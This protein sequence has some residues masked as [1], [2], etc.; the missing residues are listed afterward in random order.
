M[1]VPLHDIVVIGASAGGVETLIELCHLLPADLPAAVFVVLHMPSSAPGLLP[2][3]LSRKGALPAVFA[4]NDQ[5]IDHKIIY[6]APPD[7]HML[8]TENRV[9]LSSGPR[10]NMLRPAADTLF[11]S[12]AQA[13]G[14]RVV[15]IVL[16]GTRNDGT[17]GML[18]IQQQGGV[19]IVQDPEEALFPGMPESV[20]QHMQPAYVLKISDIAGTL[21][22]LARE[23]MAKLKEK[24]MTNQAPEEK[25]ELEQDKLAFEN[26]AKDRTPRTLL[27]CPECS[28]V[29]WEV[30][31]G[32]LT[33]YVC[34]IGHA[35][36]E[37]ALMSGQSE[38][39]ER[40]L[41][42]AVRALDERA[43]LAS[44]AERSGH[45]L[46]ARHFIHQASEAEKNAEVIRGII[47]NGS[48]SLSKVDH[49]AND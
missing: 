40:A 1:A 3:I 14:Q 23:P 12:A 7:R 35:Y 47:M 11:R 30:H 13:F 6:V 42:V 43:T 19:T 48:N 21:N 18:A 46:T 49:S 24:T 37:E 36:N 41:W 16:S 32:S 8:L 28:G 4:E 39:L 38:T 5:P 15:G 31:D 17:A 44:R 20:L 10:E 45:D 27:T 29:L 9:H 26:S 34:Q 22:Q 25:P 33:R 2:T